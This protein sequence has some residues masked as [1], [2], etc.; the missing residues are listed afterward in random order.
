MKT[1]YIVLEIEPKTPN[2]LWAAIVGEEENVFRASF[3]PNDTESFSEALNE[4]YHWASLEGDASLQT[5]F[6]VWEKDDVVIRLSEIGWAHLTKEWI[7]FIS[8]YAGMRGLPI[9]EVRNELRNAEYATF[10]VDRMQRLARLFQTLLRM[11]ESQRTIISVA[12]RVSA[13]RE[14]F[15]NDS[16]AIENLFPDD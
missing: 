9:T 15:Q 16:A 14:A 6:V 2:M 11:A 4:L 10:G 12:A 7:D 8:Y 3:T 1:K 5:Q 13:A